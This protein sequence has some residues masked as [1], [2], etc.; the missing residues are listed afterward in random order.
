M[1]KMAKEFQARFD[2]ES[3]KAEIILVK[4]SRAN[5][6]V[7]SQSQLDGIAKTTS[8]SEGSDLLLIINPT[9]SSIYTPDGMET[10]WGTSDRLVNLMFQ[11]VAS[12]LKSNERVWTAALEI[13]SE[14]SGGS[15]SWGGITAPGINGTG[16]GMPVGSTP[17]PP[18][19]I[20]RDVNKS[21][22]IIYKKLKSDR[23]ITA[24]R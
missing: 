18:R 11:I 17:R 7:L 12:D 1:S 22:D 3:I 9:H 8:P 16:G 23:V 24:V 20:L 10:I 5:A 13:S 2:E 6:A 4:L 14:N 19:S 21:V 15:A